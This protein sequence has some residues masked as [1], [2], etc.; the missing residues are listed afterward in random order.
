MRQKVYSVYEVKAH[1]SEVLREVVRTG[2]K[3]VITKH[4]KPVAEIAP[5]SGDEETMEERLERM[6]R[7]G[8]IH[9]PDNKDADWSSV[10][11]SPGALERFLKDRD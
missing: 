10:G 11:R 3:V 5:Y 9:G 1:L 6:E 4:G 2:K 7:E 8:L